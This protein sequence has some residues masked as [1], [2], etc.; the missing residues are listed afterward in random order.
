MQTCFPMSL[1]PPIKPLSGGGLLQRCFH[2]LHGGVAILLTSY[3]IMCLRDGSVQGDSH[4][5]FSHYVK[6]VS[7]GGV[8]AWGGEQVGFVCLKLTLQTSPQNSSVV[9]S[10]EFC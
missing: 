5:L 3:E 8:R 9:E 2:C 10:T 7:L 4:S 1:L 6:T